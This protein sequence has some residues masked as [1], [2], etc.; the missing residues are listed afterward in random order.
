[1]RILLAS[2]ALASALA[3]S[4][5]AAQPGAEEFSVA[6]AYGDLDVASNDGVDSFIH[7]VKARADLFCVGVG[8][9]PLQQALQAQKCRANF[10]QAAEHRLQ[11]AD[12]PSSA[13][14]AAGR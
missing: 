9:S 4:P 14:R 5:A 2:I 13:I 10:I 7:R 12:A 11:L 6:I 1:M 3:A 8:D